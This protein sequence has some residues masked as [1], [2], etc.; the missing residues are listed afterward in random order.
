M[1]LLLGSGTDIIKFNVAV[2]TIS[3]YLI[4]SG[5]ILSLNPRGAWTKATH[6]VHP[7]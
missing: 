4:F 7:K 3:Y 5:V 1:L 6:P 2:Y